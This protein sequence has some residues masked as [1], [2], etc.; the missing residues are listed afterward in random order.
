MPLA[1]DYS[2]KVTG[3]WNE[4][5]WAFD[6]DQVSYPKVLEDPADGLA[7]RSNHLGDFFMGKSIVQVN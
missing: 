4:E 6:R 2:F 5:A 3:I 7:R 1:A